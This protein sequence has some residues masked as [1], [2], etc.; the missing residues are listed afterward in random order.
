[1]TYR[2]AYYMHEE[3]RADAG[4]V[5]E[6]FAR[7]ERRIAPHGRRANTYWFAPLGGE[8]V[9]R[10]DVDFDAG[11]AA[12]RWLADGTFAADLEVGGAIVV[13]ESSDVPP[14]TIPG[15]LARVSIDGVRRAVIGL[16]E[17]GQRPVV[18]EW[19]RISDGVRRS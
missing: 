17:T 1:M 5:V 10:A 19:H 8:D 11:R 15:G 9:L 3:L 16:V 2:V 18:V 7:R 6:L 12:L 14:V 4:A 13:L